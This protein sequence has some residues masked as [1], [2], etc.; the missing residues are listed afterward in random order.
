MTATSAGH[1]VADAVP[2][3]RFDAFISYSH[4][5][6]AE[7]APALRRG[8][9]QLAKPWYRVRATKIFVDEASLSTSPALWLNITTALSSS[10]YLVLLCS[11]EAARSEW[12]DK[13]VAHWLANRSAE[14]LLP[15]LTSGELVWDPVACE[16]DM[17]RSTAAPPALRCAFQEEPRHLDVRWIK[18]GDGQITLSLQN[19]R[20]KD[21]VADLAAP[22]H[23]VP[24]DDLVGE[25]VRQNLRTRRL[26]RSAVS[27]L[28]ILL[29]V[30]VVSAGLARSNSIR[31]EHRRIDSEARRLGLE[32][33]GLVGPPDL[34]FTLAAEG[35]RLRP[36]AVTTRA[37][38]DT[39]EAAPQIEKLF[40]PQ[41]R[42]IRSIL[43]QRS[44]KR[45]LSVDSNGSMIA[46]DE[47]SG[48]PL[49]EA[50]TAANPL[51]LL[52]GPGGILV[53]TR[54]GLHVHD[55]L[56]LAPID[57]TDLPSIRPVT[58]AAVVGDGVAIGGL[59]E[60]DSGELWWTGSGQEPVASGYG[61]PVA[62]SAD[63]RA[64]IALFSDAGH[65]SASVRRF[66]RTDNGWTQ[67]WA[68]DV[69][70]TNTVMTA[71][72]A[73]RQLAIG[74]TNGDITFIDMDSGNSSDPLSV[75]T[76]ALFSLAYL[77]GR[78]IWVAGDASGTIHWIDAE[79]R[80]IQ[81]SW[82]VHNGAVTTII[83]LDD[84]TYVSGGADGTLARQRISPL[85]KL[86]ATT[87][88]LG[89][90]GFS[91][92]AHPESGVA[93]AGTVNRLVKVDLLT[94]RV[95]ATTGID[96]VVYSV[97]LLPESTGPSANKAP[98]NNTPGNNTPGSNTPGSVAVGDAK[99]HIH[100]IRNGRV[101]QTVETRSAT[102]LQL[103]AVDATRELIA[104]TDDGNLSVY[105]VL[106][107]RLGPGRSI[108]TNGFVA[109]AV[110]ADGQRVAYQRESGRVEIL[111]IADGKSV[112]VVTFDD[113]GAAAVPTDAG[114][115]VLAF[116]DDATSLAVGFD[117]SVQLMNLSWKGRALVASALKV[118]LPVEA[119]PVGIGYAGNSVLVADSDGFV[120]SFDATTGEPLGVVQAFLASRDADVS[121]GPTKVFELAGDAL[122][123]RNVTPEAIRLDACAVLWRPLSQRER[124]RFDI[125]KPAAAC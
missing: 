91:V 54:D 38:I 85:R 8:L 122:V 37:L 86:A 41:G 42:A 4:S 49:A 81:G 66:E 52:Q 39:A 89:S 95:V 109:L 97:A 61:A 117:G 84:S 55:A 28:C 14:N 75:G 2:P 78:G 115:E 90:E 80:Q 70:A 120:S 106:N 104:L 79:T 72:P 26:A 71:N 36:T 101:V 93:Y 62:V 59:G 44:T 99:G 67:S 24:K 35:Y 112:G 103:I 40:R 87:I 100:V 83:A 21:A 82:S 43:Y 20:F 47:I 10:H 76:S 110:S 18:G 105:P 60:D 23:G 64:M 74:A 11:P 96:S 56:S 46:M 34:A 73:T 102:V 30:S 107:G 29:L 3:H 118:I 125:A 7:L 48:K 111:S 12:V 68:A 53:V 27:I 65:Q 32:A 1:P 69:A 77:T 22:I 9:H 16:L 124:I 63:G 108:G 121:H 6:D 116:N 45:I 88:P 92:E 119:K 50:K 5:A 114:V 58:S 94:N 57:H 123:I 17:V 51:R 33:T 113:R 15:V 19:S 25:D 13:E 31:A 98:G